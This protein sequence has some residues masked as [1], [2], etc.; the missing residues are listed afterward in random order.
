MGE[1]QKSEV[2]E[3]IRAIIFDFDFTLADSSK[4]VEEC[5]SYGFNMLDLPIP[6]KQEIF[7]TIGLSLKETFITLAGIQNKNKAEAF[8]HYFIQKADEVMADLTVIFDDVPN[9]IHLLKDNGILIGIVSTKFRYRIESILARENLLE[10]F[11]VI[12]GAEDV[13]NHKPN[14][15]SLLLALNKLNLS[16]SNVLYIGDSLT[17]AEAAKSAGISFGPVLSGMA[18]KESFRNYQ[19]LAILNNI[20]D[21]LKLLGI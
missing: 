9:V 19:T 15:E 14:P 5:V 6:S 21:L 2:M 18:S 7:K 3:N 13:M 20:S 16:R 4:G 17:D 10:Y 1:N 12:I 11:D 8:S